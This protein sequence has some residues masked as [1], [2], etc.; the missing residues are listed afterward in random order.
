MGH[1]R[2]GIL[3]KTKPWIRIVDELNGSDLERAKV[4]LVASQTLEN[5]RKR[6]SKI[7]DD[8]GV[9]ASFKF[10]VTLAVSTQFENPLSFLTNSGIDIGNNASPYFVAKALHKYVESN[11][12]SLEYGE[13][14]WTAAVDSISMW[15]DK[16]SQQLR[17]FDTDKN[18][19]ETWRGTGLGDG[20][21]EISRMFFAK[22][23][24]R[25]LNYFLER[26]LSASVK[27]LAERDSLRTRLTEHVDV[28]S[29]HAFETAKIT[30]S[31]AAGWFNKHANQKMPS[32]GEIHAFLR[33][34]FG[35]LREE[36]R[37]EETK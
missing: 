33:I 12:G 25:Y 13:I 3:P 27:T 20:F 31:F 16:N 6:L 14:A 17:M 26:A 37:R 8:A 36:L 34:A 19:L 5:V 2:L 30:Q 1:E 32:D 28:A 10:L 35:K 22:T 11:I 29:K 9:I 4:G 15:H 21:C 24:E 23:T 7:E 18:S